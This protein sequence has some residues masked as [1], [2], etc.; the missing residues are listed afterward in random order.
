MALVPLFLAS[1]ASADRVRPFF[2]MNSISNRG[3]GGFV[4]L[5]ISL[6]LRKSSQTRSFVLRKGN[7]ESHPAGHVQL[8]ISDEGP[9]PVS[10]VVIVPRGARV[11]ED[12]TSLVQLRRWNPNAEV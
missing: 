9:D 10:D 2:L 6:G 7:S 8:R 12:T 4:R 11:T 3:Q 5:K 1:I